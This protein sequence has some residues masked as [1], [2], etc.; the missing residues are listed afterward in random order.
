MGH[1]NDLAVVKRH[2]AWQVE[3]QFGVHEAGDLHAFDDFAVTRVDRIT[4]GR[5][6]CF[7]AQNDRNFVLA[8]VLAQ[9]LALA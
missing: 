9:F 7:A 3:P 4:H 8:R 2:V 1:R 6:G 5:C